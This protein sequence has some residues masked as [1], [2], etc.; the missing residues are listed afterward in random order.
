MDIQEAVTS[1][2]VAMINNDCLAT[3]EQVSEA[4]KEIYTTVANPIK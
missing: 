4:Y 2:I 3:S 1:I